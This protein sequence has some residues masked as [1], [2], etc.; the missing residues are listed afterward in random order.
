M[1]S[2]I[3]TIAPDDTLPACLTTCSKVHSQA[4]SPECYTVYF[5]AHSQPA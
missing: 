4:H 1:L 5:M 2:N 3:L